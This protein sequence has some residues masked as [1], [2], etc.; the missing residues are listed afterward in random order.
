MT[1]RPAVPDSD[2]PLQTPSG[3]ASRGE[4]A[5]PLPWSTNG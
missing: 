4:P 1:A 2:A 5:G 3:D